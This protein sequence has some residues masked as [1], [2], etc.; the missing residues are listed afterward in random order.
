MF[1]VQYCSKTAG[2]GFIDH[3]SAVLSL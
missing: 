2:F 3:F 1:I